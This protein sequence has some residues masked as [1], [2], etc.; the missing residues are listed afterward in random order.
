MKP[1]AV[2]AAFLLS[3]CSLGLLDPVKVESPRGVIDL[4]NWNFDAQGPVEPQAWLWDPLLRSPADE[5]PDVHGLPLGPPDK[6]GLFASTLMQP[7]GKGGAPLAGATAR[8]RVLVTDGKNYG[9]QIGA[10][11]GAVKV[12]VNGDVVWESGVVSLNPRFFKAD[13]AGAVVTVQPRDGVLDIVAQMVSKDPLIRHSEVNRLW[14]IGPATPM[15]ESQSWERSWRF[16]QASVLLIGIVV[17][18]WISRLRPERRALV[19]FTWFLGSC[20]LKLLVNVEQPQ[21]LLNGLIPGVPLSLYLILNH[22]LNLLPFPLMALF[23]I[24]QFPLDLKMPAFWVITAGAIAATLWELLPFA[25][26]A[27][28]WEALYSGIMH[29]QWAFFLNL[30]VVLATLFLF[31]RFYHVFSQNRPLSRALFLGALVMGIIVLLPVPLSYFLPVKHTYFLGWGMFLFLMILAFALIRLQVRATEQEVADLKQLLATREPLARYIS[32]EW[33]PRLGREDVESLR[34]GDRREAEAILVRVSSLGERE[35]WLS[36]VGQAAS[37][38]RAVL[39]SWQDGAG[40]WVLEALPETALAFA[41]DVRRAVPDS[42]I[43]V[44]RARVEFRLLDLGSRWLPLVT[45][46]PGRLTELAERARRFGATL[47]LSGELKDGLVVGGWRR[48]RNL[49]VEGSEIELYEAD[50]SASDKDKT[51]EL[52]ETG[53]ARARE[54]D[55][56]GAAACMRQLLARHEDAGAE[57]LVAEWKAA[58]GA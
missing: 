19:F 32:P 17:F 25:V 31:E 21:P 12:W 14:A 26:L 50:A 52:W 22:G 27:A 13:G 57:V 43:T 20:L 23:L 4:T 54:G 2:L 53:L 16:L 37:P 34:P 40:I 15:L 41:L 9:F 10:L 30:Y 35:E 39:A 8:I 51:L 46:V 38:W 1:A 48:H 11:P 24:R 47:V 58:S 18:F 3:G 29:A 55:F 6:G 7:H 5:T 45:G 36:A 49:S 42:R 44:L 33:A 56:D 28:G